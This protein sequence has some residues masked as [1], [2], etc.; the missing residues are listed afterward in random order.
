M[1]EKGNIR[2]L[3]V[4]SILIISIIGIE[5]NISQGSYSPYS[6][7]GIGHIESEGF[8]VIHSMG[9]AGIALKSDRFLNNINPASYS[10][11]DSMSFSFE[12]GL[13][14]KQ[15]YYKTNETTQKDFNA[16]LQY[17]AMGFRINRWW[18]TS[19]GIVPVSN[20]NYTINVTDCID[21]SNLEFIKTFRGEG[22]LNRFYSGNSFC[23]SKNLTLGLNASYIF[24]SVIQEESYSILSYFSIQEETRMSV[25]YF[26]FGMQYSFK[27]FNNKAT[28][29]L[30]YGNRSDL[31]VFNQKLLYQLT[32]TTDLDEDTKSILMPTCYGI[33]FSIEKVFKYKIAMD[34]AVKD[35]S[36]IDF[37]NPLLSTR[38]SNRISA[39]LEIIPGNIVHHDESLKRWKYRLGA[40]YNSTYLVIDE[41]PINSMALTFGIGMPLKMNKSWINTSFEFGN[42]GTLKN[43]LI[44]EKYWLIHLN[45]AMHE[46]WFQ[47][48]KFD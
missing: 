44:L 42:Y 47:K 16:N 17:L 29:G 24:G 12:F 30:V 27:L 18:G 38:S 36:G 34:Y 11:I 8:G 20:V 28:L 1:T 19:I 41:V 35:W 48:R 14:G 21:G 45:L 23:I 32:D 37:N 15:S 25:L 9:G 7:F 46:M 4:Y 13:V 33:G 10:G 43:N 2:F 3:R 22:A 39:G 31:E 6:L 26:D 40:N 5:S